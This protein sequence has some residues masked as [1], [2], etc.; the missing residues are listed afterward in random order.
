M[1]VP[2]ATARVKAFLDRVVRRGGPLPP[3]RFVAELAIG[4]ISVP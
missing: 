1:R 2:E 3:K 4:S